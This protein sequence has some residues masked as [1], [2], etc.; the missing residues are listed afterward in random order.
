MKIPGVGAVGAALLAM[1][2]R[3]PELF[4]SGRQFSA[5]LGLT[6]KDHST[7]GKARLGVITRAGDEGLRAVLVAGATV[8]VSHVRAGTSKNAFAPWVGELLKR[9]AP[10]LVA[11]ALAN[12]M[13]RIAWKLMAT[14]QAYKGQTTLTASAAD[15]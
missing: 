4:K 9:K 1:K 11:V 6:P 12:K 3:A 14:G 13:A 2:T 8:I 15:A 5:W 10:K 7:A